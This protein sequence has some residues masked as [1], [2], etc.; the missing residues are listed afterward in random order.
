M[1]KITSKPNVLFVIN[2]NRKNGFAIDMTNKE[3][4]TLINKRTR[5]FKTYYNAVIKHKLGK[6]KKNGNISSNSSNS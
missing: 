5:E 3:L 4:T 1:N 6:R 2:V